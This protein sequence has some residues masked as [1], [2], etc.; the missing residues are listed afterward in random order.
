M[1]S[2]LLCVVVVCLLLACSKQNQG[3]DSEKVVTEALIQIK[4]NIPDDVDVVGLKHIRTIKDYTYVECRATLVTKVDNF[5]IQ[6]EVSYDLKKPKNPDEPIYVTAVMEGIIADVMYAI[7]RDPNLTQ[8][9]VDN[10]F[11]SLEHFIVYKTHRDTYDYLEEE[12]TDNSSM[13]NEYYMRIMEAEQM[14][15]GSTSDFEKE[16]LLQ[17]IKSSQESINRQKIMQEQ[18]TLK[19]EEQNKKMERIKQDQ[20]P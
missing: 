4:L 9:A 6:G 19:L 11:S 8:E 15:S 5:N 2:L 13:I 17:R 1:K 3:C 20:S 14:L 12:Y 7:K 16:L 10:G 18:L